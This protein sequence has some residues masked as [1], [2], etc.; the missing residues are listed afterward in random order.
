MAF[1]C[2]VS[3]IHVCIPISATWKQHE[4]AARRVPTPWRGH[5]QGVQATRSPRS[6]RLPPVGRTDQ[7]LY[8]PDHWICYSELRKVIHGR[9]SPRQRSVDRTIML[10]Y[11]LQSNL[12][13]FMK[14]IKQRKKKHE[15]S[16]LI[17]LTCVF[18]LISAKGSLATHWNCQVVDRTAM[19]IKMQIIWWVF[20]WSKVG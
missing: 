8:R 18:C 9:C 12:D 20:H 1:S 14:W 15:I 13:L 2:D 11:S 6:S 19:K 7:L 4:E 10:G 17:Q 3:W 5:Q 16:S